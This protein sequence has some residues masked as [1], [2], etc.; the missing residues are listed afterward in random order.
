MKQLSVVI[1]H[2]IH[3]FAGTGSICD[4]IG[5][6]RRSVE[7]ICELCALGSH[8]E[9]EGCRLLATLV[10]YSKDVGEVGRTE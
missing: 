9:M 10:K 5:G 1:Q 8:L 7:R 2:S 6:S 3:C 4:H